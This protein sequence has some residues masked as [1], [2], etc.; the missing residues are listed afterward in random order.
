[1]TLWDGNL[2]LVICFGLVLKL[3]NFLMYKILGHWWDLLF[4][5]KFGVVK[6]G[7]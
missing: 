1:M 6:N 5:K 2:Q 4:M 7:E 3:D